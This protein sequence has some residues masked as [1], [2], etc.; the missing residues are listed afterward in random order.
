MAAKNSLQILP[1]SPHNVLAT[2]RREDSDELVLVMARYVAPFSI[3]APDY[4][5]DDDLDECPGLHYD[6]YIPHDVD[7]ETD[8]EYLA[9]G[10]YF[11]SPMT[12]LFE[13]Y[14]NVEKRVTGWTEIVM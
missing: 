14:D 1:N 4:S 13:A 3:E 7:T 9:S 2:L 10:W 12:D 6:S 8:V 5:R 11:Y